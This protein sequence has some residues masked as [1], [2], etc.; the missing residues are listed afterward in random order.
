MRAAERIECDGSCAARRVVSKKAKAA[1]WLGPVG[2]V[3]AVIVPKGLCPIC[4]AMSGS[5]LSSLGLTFLANDA[6][7]RWLLAGIL[8]VALFA[9][10][11]VA[12]RKERWAMFGVAAAGAVAVYGGW[13]FSSKVAVYSGSALLVVAS[14]LNLWRPRAAS[15]PII[16][17][18]GVGL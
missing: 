17:D 7:M 1:G 15:L 4:L 5:V 9:F 12:R 14:V 8:G 10:F 16:S 3:L 13:M 2:G 11:V 6:V 18:E